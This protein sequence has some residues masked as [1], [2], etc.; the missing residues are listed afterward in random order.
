[1]KMAL[2]VFAAAALRRGS[3]LRG[4]A[5]P[6]AATEESVRSLTAEDLLRAFHASWFKPDNATL[7]VV[8]DT[9]MA[10]IVPKLERLFGGWSARRACPKRSWPRNGRRAAAL[11]GLSHRPPRLAPVGGLRRP[12]RAAQ[13]QP[14]R[15]RDAGL[16][17]I[18]GGSFTSR[19]NMN[20]R[21]DKH[22]S[23]GAHS[24]LYDAR[25]QRP[26]IVY[27]SVQT[28]K[29]A[30]AL[31]EIQRELAGIIGPHPPTQ[32][33]RARSPPSSASASPTTTGG[34]TPRKSAPSTASRPNRPAGDLLR[35]DALTWVVVGDLEK[36]GEE[37]RALGLGKA[38]VIDAEGRPVED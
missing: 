7:I 16:N 8:G 6:E 38:Q 36:I 34:T 13:G 37:V 35:P 12:P 4:A 19:I 24:F 26:F 11:A 5:S 18:L 2:R 20:L 33:W 23:Y 14:R 31:A 25:G 29:T 1:M 21:E 30:P 3:R 15:G 9:T 22:W 10:E 32:P 17:E 27:S 28:D